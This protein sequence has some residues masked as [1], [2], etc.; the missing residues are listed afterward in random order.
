MMSLIDQIAEYTDRLE[1]GLGRLTALEYEVETRTMDFARKFDAMNESIARHVAQFTVIINDLESRL[2]IADDRVDGIFD[3]AEE[4]HMWSHE[5]R[6][7]RLEQSV[8]ALVENVDSHENRLD[9]SD[10]TNPTWLN[11][12]IMTKPEPVD[13]TPSP[14]NIDLVRNALALIGYKVA[15]HAKQGEMYYLDIEPA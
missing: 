3:V 2:T 11:D 9:A 15:G 1:V 6:L 12:N 5:D 13:P 14:A 10:P 4:H 7:T 8:A